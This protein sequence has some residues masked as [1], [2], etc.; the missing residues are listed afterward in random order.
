MSSNVWWVL[1]GD[2]PKEL[3]ASS[4]HHNVISVNECYRNSVMPA[5]FNVF[6]EDV[7]KPANFIEHSVISL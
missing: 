6:Y 2:V 4:C 1:Y 7:P 3:E 5:L